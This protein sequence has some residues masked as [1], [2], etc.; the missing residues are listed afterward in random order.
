MD[1]CEEMESTGVYRAEDGL[2][3]ISRFEFLCFLLVK[4]NMI[5]IDD[6]GTIM[7]HFD[8]L[9]ADGNGMLDP[10]DL[11]S[12]MQRGAV[13]PKEMRMQASSGSLSRVLT[14]ELSTVSVTGSPSS[15]EDVNQS[16]VSER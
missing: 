6:I 9:D 2:D 8:E 5:E 15:S 7:A 14:K 16:I 11:E 13:N 3:E 4:N 1:F 12:W 10:R